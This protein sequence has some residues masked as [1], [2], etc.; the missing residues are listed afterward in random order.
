MRTRIEG[1]GLTE[2]WI[3]EQEDFEKWVTEKISKQ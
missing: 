2:I 1:E 3:S